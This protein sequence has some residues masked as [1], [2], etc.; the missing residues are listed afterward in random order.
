MREIGKTEADVFRSEEG[1]AD[2]RPTFVLV[3]S[4]GTRCSIYS[5]LH[6]TQMA[7]KCNPPSMAVNPHENKQ[8]KGTSVGVGKRLQIKQKLSRVIDESL[9]EH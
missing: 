3:E 7:L 1:M 2:E 9:M 6:V 5:G 4:Q 8:L